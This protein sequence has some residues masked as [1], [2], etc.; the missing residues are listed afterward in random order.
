MN[1]R[2]IAGTVVVLCLGVP[3]AVLL[4]LAVA[5]DLSYAFVLDWNL[6]LVVGGCSCLIEYMDTHEA[7]R[8][9]RWPTYQAA[10]GVA[11]AAQP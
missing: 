8:V 9:S 3:L 6:P 4:Q 2:R 5:S 10:T 7:A 1:T 11:E